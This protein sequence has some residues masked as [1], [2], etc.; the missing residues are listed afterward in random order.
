MIVLMVRVCPRLN[1]VRTG[2]VRRMKSASRVAAR[3]LVNAARLDRVQRVVP[4]S[5]ASVC[6]YPSAMTIVRVHPMH[7]LARHVRVLRRRG[8]I[9]PENLKLYFCFYLF[10]FPN[11]RRRRRRRSALNRRKS[12]RS[13]AAAA[14]T[15]TKMLPPEDKLCVKI[16]TTIG[17]TRRPRRKTTTTRRRH[18]RRRRR[19]RRRKRRD[20]RHHRPRDLFCWSLSLLKS[21]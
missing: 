15:M 16:R 5:N 21:I 13:D 20:G 8:Q 1:V 18:R 14:S 4:A 2:H 11:E 3:F 10:F 12:R 9:R 6:L 7:S 19:R 17:R